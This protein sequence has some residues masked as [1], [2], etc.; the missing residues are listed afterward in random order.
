LLAGSE[1]GR[2]IV[3]IDAL[4]AALPVSYLVV[5]DSVV[6]RSAPGSKLTAAVR[7]TVVGFQVD[8]FDREQHTG[9]SV[10]V[11]GNSDVVTDEAEIAKLDSAGVPSWFPDALPHY[12]RIGL[13]RI[14]GRRLD[15][16][17]G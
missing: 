13:Q 10:L 1:I 15:H 11:V 16:S 4:P 14:S 6:F 3:S 12:V 9:W 2:V 17:W 5:D 8:E 7:H